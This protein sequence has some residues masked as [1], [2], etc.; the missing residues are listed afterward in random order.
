MPSLSTLVSLA[1]VL[2]SVNAQSAITTPYTPP[3][4]SQGLKASGK[5]TPN[6]Q[7]SNILGN[8][9]YFYDIQRSGKLPADFRVSWRNDSVPNDGKDVGI[10]LSGGYFDAGNYIKATLPLCWVMTQMAWSGLTFGN[11][12]NSAAQTPYLD[13][14]L[15]QGMDWLLQASS[16]DGELV[17]IIG[18][19]KTDNVYFGGDQNIP[20]GP[21]DRPAFK[22]TRN[23]PGTDVT[24]SCAGA[25]AAASMLYSGQILPAATSGNQE[26]ADLQDDA[27]AASLLSRA[28]MLFDVAQN[29]QPQQVYQK[30]VPQVAWAYAST[31]YTDELVL[32]AALLAAATGQSNYSSYAQDTYNS[33]GYPLTSGALNWDGHG[34]ALPVIMTQAALAKPQL[35]LNANKYRADAEKYLD[36]LVSKK[37]QGA[38]YT[39][40]GL[41]YVK[42]DS[43][44]SS[45]NPALNAATLAVLYSRLATT[46][47]KTQGYLSWASSQVDYTLGNNPAN[48]VYQVG[49]HPNSPKNPQSA[50]AT[51]SF[52]GQ[53]S[54]IDTDPP[55]ERWVL[56]GGIVDGPAKDDS[57]SDRRSDWQET[58]VALD[59]V[60]PMLVLAAHRL[61]IGETT[62]P[63]YVTLTADVNIVDDG[64][65]STGAQVG[66]AIGVVVGVLLLLAIFGFLFRGKIRERRI[67]RRQAKHIPL[68]SHQC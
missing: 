60:S 51:G 41:F 32:G 46:S 48:V 67:R 39:R 45:L 35:G 28:K 54:N 66:I 9:L 10:D 23:N 31:D 53:T 44:D 37:M 25:M 19:E 40:G 55:T 59:T 65:L 57:F 43:D 49:L 42:G 50:L 3:D 4:P 15:R 64:G 12:Y 22:V 26:P 16:V 21:S 11:G 5:S 14:A 56:Y 33:N 58:E 38:T 68:E 6:R 20:A 24:A 63:Y 62:D 30:A 2:V 47:Q 1:A 36:N 27:Y 52:T 29:A 13:R 8:S 61:A 17:V 7:W 34:P 18:T